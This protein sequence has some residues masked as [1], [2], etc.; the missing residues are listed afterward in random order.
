MNLTVTLPLC[1]EGLSHYPMV[2]LRETQ[3]F[4]YARQ[5]RY[6]IRNSE[7]EAEYVHVY[8]R[9]NLKYV[10]SPPSKQY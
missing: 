3:H 2:T 5:E 1:Q 4:A 9:Q 7:E 10:I 6:A 8:T